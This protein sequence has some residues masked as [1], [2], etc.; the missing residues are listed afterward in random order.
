[1]SSRKIAVVTLGAVLLT[2]RSFAGGTFEVYTVDDLTNALSHVQGNADTTIKIHPGKYYVGDL[3]MIKG[4][5]LACMYSG[6]TG[7]GKRRIYGLG[8]DPSKTVIVGKG[9]YSNSGKRVFTGDGYT[10]VS[11]VTITGG[12]CNSG[13][14]GLLTAGLGV[15]NCIISNNYAK[16]AGGGTDGLSAYN[17]TY[18]FNCAQGGHGGGGRFSGYKTDNC[19]FATNRC[20]GTGTAAQGGGVSLGTHTRGKFYGNTAICGG[21]AHVATV[22]GCDFVG[23]RAWTTS[24]GAAIGSTY[25]SCTATNCYFRGNITTNAYTGWSGDV[26]NATTF[27]DCKFYDHIGGST[28]FAKWISWALLR[29]PGVGNLYAW[30]MFKLGFT[31][32]AK[33]WHDTQ[34]GSDFSLIDYKV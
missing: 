8:A 31:I 16:G 6:S 21:G 24:G 33:V 7:I 3:E 28:M 27:D 34:V 23:N 4:S 14:G 19:T 32:N 18:A 1:M 22:I 12:C 11:N 17:C 13:A 10:M 5:H 20:L 30:V 26:A 25:G 2:G 9:M 15:W 29:L